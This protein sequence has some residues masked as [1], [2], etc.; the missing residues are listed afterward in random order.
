MQYVFR[1]HK[2]FGFTLIELLIVIAIIALLTM[3]AMPSF[4][5]QIRKTKR[6]IVKAELMS[7]VA[8]QE[9]FF[10]N[11][12]QYATALTDLGYAGT[13]YAID[14][15]SVE[16]AVTAAGRIYTIGFFETPT[17]TAYVLE[18]VPQLDQEKD[19]LCSTLRISSIGEKTATGSGDCW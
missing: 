8:R 7:V 19:T 2:V 5:G 18:A 10:T 11:N 12:K 9:Q 1:K 14:R 15:D 16:I 6:N 17:T 13:T 3:V 4:Q